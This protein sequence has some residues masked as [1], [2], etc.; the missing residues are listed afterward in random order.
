M[1]LAG[2]SASFDRRIHAG[3]LTQLEWL[4]LCAREF[5][6]DGVALD[7][8]H[9]P[10]TD[11]EYVAQVKK[12]AVD[13]GLTIAAVL[14]DDLFA[15]APAHA[16]APGAAARFRLAAGLGAPLLIGR[17][18]AGDGSPQA[19]A[20]VIVA[21]KRVA[22]LAKTCNLTVGLRNGPGTLCPGAVELRR[23]A[24]D[25][26]SSWLRYAPDLALLDPPG[27]LAALWPYTV[28]AICAPG[29]PLSG[30]EDAG[31]P[32]GFRAFVILDGELEEPAEAARLFA[33][34]RAAANP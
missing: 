2:S 31:V 5:A 25:V 18:P 7:V 4:D 17:T 27:G 10:R 19:W 20:D 16:E 11:A 22:R 32:P 28:A 26:D 14:C 6:L 23:L 8:R 24:K 1:K 12:L 13:L 9:F 34:A 3:E 29:G 30:R 21:A 15:A 33:Q